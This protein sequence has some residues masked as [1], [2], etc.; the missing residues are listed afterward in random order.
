IPRP[1]NPFIFFRSHYYKHPSEFLGAS[2]QPHKDQNSVSR[3]AGAIWQTL[4]DCERAP[5]VEQAR[6]ERE[7]YKREYPDYRY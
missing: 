1:K 7:R 5:F 6:L 4:S 3:A 2:A